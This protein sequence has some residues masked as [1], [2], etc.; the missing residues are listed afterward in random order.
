[1]KSRPN[2]KNTRM[3]KSFRR[4][5]NGKD[6][7]NTK[8]LKIFSR[9]SD[10]IFMAAGIVLALTGVGLRQTAKGSTAFAD[11]YVQWVYPVLTGTIGRVSSL[12][13]FS[14]M[15]FGG[16]ALV[17]LFVFFT[18]RH[19]KEPMW[20]FS[21]T[22]WLAGM[23]LFLFSTACGINYYHQPFSS[24]L[25]WEMRDS[26]AVE[27]WELCRDL[28][29]RLN[30]SV[31]EVEEMEAQEKMENWEDVWDAKRYAEESI[32][33][34]K[35]LGMQYPQLSGYYPRPKPLAVSWFLSVTQLAGV[36]CPYTIE[37]NYNA[38]MTP[39][40]IPHTVC[41]E[42]S[43][44]KGFM[45]ED[46]ANFIGYLACVESSSEVF[47]YSGYMLGWIHATNALYSVSA[48]ELPDGTKTTG[49]EAYIGF[50]EEVAER[51][52]EDMNRNNLFWDQYEGKVAEAA[53]QMNDTYLKINSQ[54]DGVK[55]YGRVVD[56]MLAYYREK[57]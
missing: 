29:D 5:D 54:E 22:V 10:C 33:A 18:I 7:K 16:Y 25:N 55:S 31:Q 11:W 8:I 56:L 21:R 2:G 34:M 42:L 48:F 36:Y 19:W 6:T 50:M 30:Q 4:Q 28:T 40:N 52:R 45:R 26:S 32:E 46:E 49:R 37:A 51:A 23:M 3:L 13:P 14:L 43:H 53:N 9:K 1:M 24:Y 35:N 44:L 27:L 15:E 57:N 17:I 20:M 12:F 47:R 39:Y 38:D 41:H